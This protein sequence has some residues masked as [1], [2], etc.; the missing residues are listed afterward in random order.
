MIVF[1]TI[2]VPSQAS[3]LHS[4]GINAIG[5]ESLP[6]SA[7]EKLSTSIPFIQDS[8]NSLTAVS[9]RINGHD[10]MQFLIDTGL[11]QPIIIQKWAADQ[12]KLV[13]SQ[14]SSQFS[15][16]IHPFPMTTLQSLV[17][18]AMG[19]DK[20]IEY[21][22]FPA[23]ISDVELPSSSTSHIAGVLGLP[24]FY[25]LVMQLDF[26]QHIINLSEQ[27]DHSQLEPNA[28]VLLLNQPDPT[29]VRLFVA[30]PLDFGT[31]VSNNLLLDTGANHSSLSEAVVS[32]LHPSVMNVAS[33]LTVEGWGQKNFAFV[34][35]LSIGSFVI[36]GLCV[37]SLNSQKDGLSANAI[38]MDILEHFRV[39]L[40]FPGKQMFLDKFD[41]K[42]STSAPTTTGI[43]LKKRGTGF[44]V[45]R[46]L[47]L[48]PAEKASV[49][50]GDKVT[51]VD[52]IDLASYSVE[53][54][55]QLLD[56]DAGADAKIIAVSANGNSRQI[57][58]PRLTLYDASLY[59]DYGFLAIKR[60]SDQ[61]ILVGYIL[62]SSPAWKAGIRAGDVLTAINKTPVKTTDQARTL[63]KPWPQKA[64]TL[65]IRREGKPQSMTLDK[66]L[67]FH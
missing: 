62:C 46:V 5:L 39:T 60:S 35:K 29:N 26:S 40:D 55:Q 28:V 49:H 2:H 7:K 8:Q 9:V 31:T 1:L 24:L 43:Q 14:K 16:K 23:Y 58:L 18:K 36:S 54:A 19:D 6:A 27:L 3:I 53:S 65:K 45:Q 22:S 48:S 30:F 51:Q 38:G 10:P 67:T 21:D 37:R 42:P 12:L 25:Q 52:G 50:V 4:S 56:G 66:T 41:N 61:A 15:P 20:D 63:L 34:P 32:S 64:V 57:T 17:V 47:P 33:Q 13:P 44:F 59:P 11:N